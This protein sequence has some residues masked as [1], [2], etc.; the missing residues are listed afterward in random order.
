MKANYY[1][2]TTSLLSLLLVPQLMNAAPLDVTTRKVGMSGNASSGY[3]LVYKLDMGQEAVQPVYKSADGQVCSV[4]ADGTVTFK[5]SG[6]ATITVTAAGYDDTTVTLESDKYVMTSDADLTTLSAAELTTALKRVNSNVTTQSSSAK[7][8]AS[9]STTRVRFGGSLNGSYYTMFNS[10]TF[11]IK[12]DYFYTFVGQGAQCENGKTTVSISH[13]AEGQLCDVFYKVP[14]ATKTPGEVEQSE[15]VMEH[16]GSFSLG[17]KTLLQRMRIFTPEKLLAHASDVVLAGNTADLSAKVISDTNVGELAGAIGKLPSV[18]SLQYVKVGHVGG[19]VTAAQL[20]ALVPAAQSNSCFVQLSAGS[21]YEKSGPNLMKSDGSVY[22][23]TL[24]P[25]KPYAPAKDFKAVNATIL[26]KFTSAQGTYALCLPCDITYPDAY[27]KVFTP[28]E[29]TANGGVRFNST[30]E[31]KAGHPYLF[32]PETAEPFGAMTDVA[33]TA[34]APTPVETGSDIRFTGYY[35]AADCPSHALLYSGG[36]FVKGQT[37]AE[38]LSVYA[39]NASADRIGVE[40]ETVIN[41]IDT[42]TNDRPIG[43][44]ERLTR[45]LVALP[46]QSKGIYLSWRMLADDDDNTTFDIIRDGQVIKTGIALTTSYNDDQG[47]VNSQY[48]V[49]TRQN[50]EQVATSDAVTP[51]DNI[52]K[53]IPIDKPA[54]GTLPEGTAYNY[55]PNDC[56]TGDVDGDGEYEIILKWDSAPSYDNAQNGYTAPTLLDCYKLDGTKLWRIDLGRNIRSGAHYT[57]FLVYDFDGDGKAELICKTAPGSKDGTGRYVSEAA[58]D[59]TI[60]GIDN[61]KT[62][63]TSKG[64][65]SGGEE[66]LTVFNGETGKAIHTIYYNPNRGMGYGGAASYSAD[67][68]DGNV[69]YNRGERYLACVAFLD[70]P[71]KNPS[72]VMCRGYYTSAYLWAVNFNGQMLYTNWLHAS[73]RSS[74]WSVTDKY[75]KTTTKTGLKATAYAQGAHNIS[76]GDLDGDGCDEIMYGSAAINNDGTLLYSTDL[77]HGDAQHLGDLDPDREGLEFFMVLEKPNYGFNFRNAKTGKVYF[78]KTAKSDTGR[79]MAADIDADNRGYEM[80]SSASSTVYTCKG[81]SISGSRP[82][83]DFRLYWDGDLQDELLGD[84]SNHNQ[85]YLEKWN[86]KA[87]K[88]ERYLINGKNLYAYGSS[89]TCNSTKGTPCLTAD[90]FGDWREE[91]VFWCGADSAHLNIFTTSCPTEYRFPTLMHDR[92]YRLGVAWQNVAYNQPPHLSYYLPDHALTRFVKQGDGSVA[93]TVELG[94]AITPITY[95]FAHCKDVEIEGT[96]PDGLSLTKGNQVWTL[97]GTPTAIGK[98]SFKVKSSGDVSLKSIAQAV[99]IQVDRATGITELP[100]GQDVEVV[101]YDLNGRQVYQAHISADQVA[102]RL[103][104]QLAKGVFMIQLTSE[105]RTYHQKF[106]NQH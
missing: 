48:Q 62:Y 103:R 39:S 33:F 51:W 98:Y 11:Q 106:V 58:T 8:F 74:V 24:D 34:S 6:K 45:G 49:V 41:P 22:S 9:A 23:Y 5:T 55:R 84:M 54:G 38:G 32:Q 85:P 43:D 68:G 94:E 89:R 76:V 2:M 35:S 69:P 60:L 96:L 26:K 4:S 10:F 25:S 16:G 56:S 95:Q 86:T 93:Q 70:G 83:Y 29:A 97:S 27:G 30:D 78:R 65:V 92:M 87:K 53:Q 31:I 99:T 82:S 47:N 88:I 50:G 71:D 40:L 67:W 18:A 44:K 37:P 59:K 46:S 17:G 61:T 13:P 42:I 101:V 28:A 66:L 52:F 90:L 12:S 3:Y 75:G 104:R 36:A 14:D 79:G 100:A 21:Y 80:W 77:R 20:S 19:Q 63:L 73:T 7:G 1:K 102:P 105:G 57:Q 91:M 15:T 72:A 81:D 64:H